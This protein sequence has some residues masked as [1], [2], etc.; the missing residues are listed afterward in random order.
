MRREIIYVSFPVVGTDH[1][2]CAKE[3]VE[4][5]K[6]ANQKAVG[7]AEGDAGRRGIRR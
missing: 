2:I 1:G 3:E 6:G 7:E 4:V 5:I